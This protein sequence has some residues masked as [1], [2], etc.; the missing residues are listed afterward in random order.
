ML[1]DFGDIKCDWITKA[2][3]K[4]SDDDSGR[5]CFEKDIKIKKL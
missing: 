3:A 5:Q 1:G 2:Q 4:D